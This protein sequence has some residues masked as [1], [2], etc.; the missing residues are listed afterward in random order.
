MTMNTMTKNCMMWHL[1]T[2]SVKYTCSINIV[3]S[4]LDLI[5]PNPASRP[6][7][8][9][10]LFLFPLGKTFE[11]I[12]DDSPCKHPVPS[13]SFPSPNL[14]S[15]TPS[16]GGIITVTSAGIWGQGLRV[17]P[18]GNKPGFSYHQD[19]SR[20][21]STLIHDQCFLEVWVDLKNKG[22]VH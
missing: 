6:L 4:L 12:N 15:I 8:F 22:N 11:I 20:N 9:H 5:V 14:N 3:M 18:Y 10:D 13:I 21:S 19:D 2:I 1:I 7:S 16:I 17:H